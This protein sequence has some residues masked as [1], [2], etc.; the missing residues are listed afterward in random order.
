MLLNVKTYGIRV[1]TLRT[2]LLVLIDMSKFLY[3]ESCPQCGSKDNL[4]VW[5]DGHKWCFGCKYYEQGHT[6]VKH[7]HEQTQE[8]PKDTRGFP[9]DA[10]YYVPAVPMKWLLS[11]GITHTEQRLFGIQWSEKQQLLCW[12]IGTIGWQGRCFSPTAKT[13]YISHGKIHET[14]FIL[15]Q[16]GESLVLVEDF[17]SA[18]RVS[19][20]L[21]CMPLFGCVVSLE[22]LTRLSK[23]FKTVLVWLDADKLDNARKIGLNA[24]TVGLDSRVIYTTK[25]PKEYSNDEIKQTLEET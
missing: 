11:C 12:H 14:P 25:D 1:S 5:E 18:L 3:H 24:N 20:Y 13:K 10:A 15:E 16:R 4:G 6:N 17:I 19:K 7:V 2:T 9:D 23:R 22:M 8:K 21:P